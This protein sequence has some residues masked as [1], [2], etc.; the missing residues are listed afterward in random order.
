[1][2]TEISKTKTIVIAAF[3]ITIVVGAVFVTSNKERDKQKQ[4][5]E[6]KEA[7]EK[8][9]LKGFNKKYDSGHDSICSIPTR[10]NNLDSITLRIQYIEGCRWLVRINGTASDKYFHTIRN[11]PSCTKFLVS[12]HSEH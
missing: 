5:Q 12:L 6:D 10:Y 7:Y 3:I 4:K 1:M 9:K 8:T 2:K 11:C